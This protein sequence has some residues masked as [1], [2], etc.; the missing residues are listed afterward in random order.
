[1]TDKL[2]RFCDEYLIDLNGAA[3][4]ARAGY[5]ESTAKQK[6]YELLHR[7]DAKEYIASRKKEIEDQLGIDAFFVR[8]RFKEISDRCMTAEPVLIFDGE[9]WVESGE[10]KFDSSGAVRAT[11]C[12]GK[13]I[14]VFKV[15]NEQKQAPAFVVFDARKK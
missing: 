5:S 3:A 6:A 11:E 9:N 8:K 7:E 13:I 4:A 1:M 10:Y 15:D 14:G 12:L 2:K